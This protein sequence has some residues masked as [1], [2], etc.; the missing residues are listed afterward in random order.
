LDVIEKGLYEVLCRK[1]K[2]INDLPIQIGLFVYRATSFG[3]FHAKLHLLEFFHL[4]IWKY[5][6]KRKYCF[7]KSDTD[8]CYFAFSEVSIDSCVY[9]YLN[10]EY[11]TKKPKW[12][13]VDVCDR[14][15]NDYVD[16]KVQDRPWNPPDFCLEQGRYHLRQ[17]GLFKL[18]HSG[19][20]SVALTCKSYAVSG[21]SYKQ[22]S[23]GVSKKQNPLTL[24]DYLN[25]L[26]T[27]NPRFVTN[28]G[29]QVRNHRVYTYSQRKRGLNSFITNVTF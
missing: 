6:E 13:V 1:P 24:D 29:F 22:I 2:I 23:K 16:A 15:L 4:F 21:D 11:F 8:S 5:L 20:E 12:M 25:V 7:V 18:E 17:C 28:R 9:P 26:E 3:I 10:K 14:Y 19:F 27:D